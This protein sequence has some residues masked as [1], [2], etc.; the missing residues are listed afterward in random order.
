VHLA[1]VRFLRA[2]YQLASAR[3]DDGLASA[4]ARAAERS[5]A[6]ARIDVPATF[7]TINGALLN[8]ARIAVAEPTLARLRALWVVIGHSGTESLRP[9]LEQL[10][11][12]WD[13]ARDGRA[14]E[15]ARIALAEWFRRREGA[16]AR[17]LA[18]GP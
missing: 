8:R 7:D 2:L 6:G 14:R 11:R 9:E 5:A 17:S 1:Q 4:V 12:G 10:A 3:F 16:I 15:S 18:R 13:R